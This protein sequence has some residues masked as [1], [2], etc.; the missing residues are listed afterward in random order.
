MA[1][2]LCF[3]LRFPARRY[4]ATPWGAHVNEGQIEWPPSPWRLARALLSVGFT[5]LGWSVVPPEAR[6]LLE[7]MAACPPSY[8]LPEASLG[9]TRHYMPIP[10]NTT[11][12]LDAFAYVGNGVL[13]VLY[14]GDFSEAEIAIA[15]ALIVR[16][17]YLGRAESWVE[18]RVIPTPDLADF[19]CR[20]LGEEET[21]SNLES[22]RLLAPELPEAYASWREVEIGNALARAL[23]M[24]QR[25]A[26]ARGRSVPS[27]LGK[28][29]VEKIQ[30]TFP[31]S[32]MDGLLWE[33]SQVQR[34]KS[35]GGWNVPPGSRWVTYRMP[36]KWRPRVRVTLPTP[37]SLP[38][39]SDTALL[40]L[41]ADTKRIDLYPPMRDALRRMEVLHSSLVSL[42]KADAD[43]HGSP[44]FTGK[45]DGELLRGHRH[46]FLI[47]L[48]LGRR[49]D[50]I[51][52]VL[53]H[54]PM[55]FD[56]NALAALRDIR[57]TYAQ[58]MPEIFVTLVGLGRLEDFEEA[59]PDTREAMRWRS[60]TPFVPPRFLK[61]RGKNSLRGQIEAELAERG[62]DDL[63]AVRMESDDGILVTLDHID[64][65]TRPSRRFRHFRRQRQKLASPTRQAFSLELE[66]ATPVRGPIALGYACH[67][68]LGAFAPVETWG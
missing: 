62:I 18:G 13:Q 43:E 6:S 45:V 29:D 60:R 20:P 23:E 65:R 33:T 55:S 66:F 36:V 11:K 40:A 48:A 16:L 24:K 30:Q 37:H 10:G 67:F 58:G 4:H 34:R 68:G 49:F 1:T 17:P 64:E 39:A 25:E 3:E 7:K 28:K 19:E 54:A 8:S 27:K 44:V 46:A 42:S 12:V 2:V 50:R 41:S 47:P 38:E 26:E 59:V 14:E 57:K 35:D 32:M 53:V 56:R 21:P 22:R 51:D 63:V 5:R 15:T 61:T 52:H 9:H 31:R